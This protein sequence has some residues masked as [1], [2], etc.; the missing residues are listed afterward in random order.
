MNNKGFLIYAEGAEYVRQ[1]YLCAMSIMASHNSYPVSIVT[2]NIVPDEYLWAFDKV[3]D[4]PWY[5]FINSRFKTEHRWKLYHVSPYDQTIV[6][7][8]DILVLHDLEYFWKFLDNRD[9]YFPTSV[10]TYRA[11]IIHDDYYRQA[12]TA[13]N[14]PNVYNAVHYFRKSALAHEFY[15]WVEL[16]TTNWELFYGNFCKE[17]YPKEPSMDITTAIVARIMDIDDDIT[18]RQYL[19]PNIVHMK[20]VIQGWKNIPDRWQD[21]VGVY[22]TDDCTLKIG[23][24][25]QNTIFHYTENS[26][27]TSRIIG[28]YEL[29]LNP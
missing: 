10:M 11:E 26:F 6:L 18:N 24:Y 8:S 2:N 14:L 17:Y 15:A 9:L 19:S 28:K 3:I 21:T 7:D 27:V 23:N 5:T 4:I 1:S 13:N 12:F 22:L 20:P 16:V 25:L 29:C